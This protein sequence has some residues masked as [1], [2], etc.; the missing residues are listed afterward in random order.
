MMAALIQVSRDGSYKEM[1][2]IFDSNCEIDVN[3][4]DKVR[5]YSLSV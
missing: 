2:L 3:A 5:L 4:T 1:A